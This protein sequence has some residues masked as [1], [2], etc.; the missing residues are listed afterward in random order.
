MAKRKE[1]AFFGFAE[2]RTT[3]QQAKTVMEAAKH[4]DNELLPGYAMLSDRYEKL[5]KEMNK[6][7]LIS[8]RQSNALIRM[9]A[10]MKTLLD[11]VGQGFLTVDGSLKVQ[12]QTSSECQR[13]FDRKISG[14]N[15]TELLWPDDQSMRDKAES[16]LLSAMVEDSSSFLDELPAECD[17]GG[18]KLRLDYKKIQVP[19]TTEQVRIM[20]VMTDVTEQRK[21]QKRL[22]YMSSHDP[23]TGLWNR[24]HVDRWMDHNGKGSERPFSLIMADMNGLKLVNDVFGHLLGD[25]LLLK[26]AQILLSVFGEKAICARW[27]GDEFL[28]LL[29]NTDRE[30]CLGLIDRLDEACQASDGKPIKISMSVGAATSSRP[31]DEYAQLFLHAEKEMYKKKMLESRDSRKRLMENISDT[32]YE[33]GIEDP[34]HV[35]RI[36][37]LASELAER[38][39][40]PPQSPQMNML[41]MLARLHDVGKIAIP[42]ELLANEEELTPEQ[43]EVVRNHSEIGYRLAFSLGEPAL[44]EAI[45]SMQEHWDGTGYPYGLKHD[46]IPEFSRLL[47]VVDAYDVMTERKPKP[48][49]TP[50]SREKALKKLLEGSGSRF[51]PQVVAEF[52]LHMERKE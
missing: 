49:R 35:E 20:I 36:A 44:A 25:E 42:Q 2:E 16:L 21:S 48:N 26:A 24:G 31:Q 45:L 22:E 40:I 3:L 6:V 50:L 43:W 9:E 13:L 34:R 46:Q 12:R 28:I 32:M 38:M 19:F 7:L 17:L 8:D 18:K 30:E 27:G 29:P 51:D 14:L 15:V 5:L 52:V 33:Q 4:H 10:E 47:A 23:L 1:D 37:T 41:K 39:G 11:N